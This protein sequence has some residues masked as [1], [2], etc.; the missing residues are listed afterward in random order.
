[1]A[2]GY[3]FAVL[4][5]LASG[6]GSI[7]ES[8]GVRRAGVYGGASV[9]LIALRH[10]WIYFLGLGVDVLGFVFAAAALHRLPLFL[11]QSLLAFSIGVTATIS[12]F[13]GTRL[14]AAGWGALSIGAAGLVLLGVSAE[15]GP[16]R[17]LPPQWRWI[18][19]GAVVPIAAIA[20]FSRHRNEK[21][22]AP[23]LAFGSGLGYCVVGISAR[24][25]TVPDDV[26]R[27]VLEPTAWTIVL[28]GFA[29]AVLFA[30]ALQKGG[31]TT[32]TAIMFT[33]NTAVSS[34][35]GLT[36]LDDRVRVGFA[37]PAAAGFALA[38]AGAIAI[39]HYAATGRPVGDPQPAAG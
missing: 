34:L 7:L 13:L 1:M 23:A 36:Y 30:M 9:D 39:A 19:A 26:W 38:I 14:V 18:L 15:P 29:A 11:V 27:L 33:T 22:A 35:V 20:A 6:S 3:V 25:L 16:A 21:W 5:T 8:I 37:V 28:N 4:A 10:Q 24:T 31:A 32:V 2:L 12:A 17:D